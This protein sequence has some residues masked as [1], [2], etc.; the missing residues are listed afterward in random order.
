VKAAI[1]AEDRYKLKYLDAFLLFSAP[2]ERVDRFE[3][4]VASRP[5][6]PF[7]VAYTPQHWSEMEGIANLMRSRRCSM[8]WSAAPQPAFLRLF[9]MKLP[10]SGFQEQQPPEQSG[11]PCFLHRVQA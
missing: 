8:S 11:R 10:D 3:E 7:L 5:D 9:H 4:L 6:R 2:K 1:S